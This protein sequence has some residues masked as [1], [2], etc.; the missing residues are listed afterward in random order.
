MKLKR[1]I[2]LTL[3]VSLLGS[4]I[5]LSETNTETE[6]TNSATI[7]DTMI[8]DFSENVYNE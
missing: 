8:W 1:F 5:C 7:E 3:I 2:S 4:A 6:A